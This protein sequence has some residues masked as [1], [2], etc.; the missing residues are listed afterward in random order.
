[1]AQPIPAAKVTRAA[2][3]VLAEES[4]AACSCDP[5]AGVRG[6]ARASRPRCVRIFSM[7]GCQGTEAL[8]FARHKRSS[9]P[10]VSGLTPQDRRTLS[11]SRA[12]QAPGAKTRP[13]I[14]LKKRKFKR[15]FFSRSPPAMLLN[16]HLCGPWVRH[17]PVEGRPQPKRASSV[18]TVCGFY[19]A[20]GRQASAL[21]SSGAADPRGPGLQAA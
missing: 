21:R 11:V 1:M 5:R 17:R 13:Q 14:L 15:T 6:G 19:R 4:Q 18:V 7:T 16:T 10:F 8:A 20:I 3:N 2:S 9:G 12:R